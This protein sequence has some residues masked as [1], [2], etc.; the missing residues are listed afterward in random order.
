MSIKLYI[1]SPLGFNEAG[2]FFMQQ[3]LFPLLQN[4]NIQIIDPWSLTPPALINQISLLHQGPN[5]ISQWQVLNKQI[6][7]NNCNGILSADAM[8]AI[9]DGADI[10]SGTAAE[11]GFAAAHKKLI[12]GYRND[13]RLA[14]DN[15]GALINLQVQYF[16]QASGG[17]ILNSLSQLNSYLPQLKIVK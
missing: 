8:L 4:H 1:A 10:D 7:Q 13:F 12:I 15:E 14:G 3:C 5:R 11:I 6:A 2:Q 16:I 9:L 17:V